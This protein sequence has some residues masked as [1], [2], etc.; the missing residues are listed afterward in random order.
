MGWRVRISG[1]GMALGY[2]H[3]IYKQNKFPATCPRLRL[4]ERV[5]L[6]AIIVGPSRVTNRDAMSVNVTY[7]RLHS[8]A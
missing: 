4:A 8:F 6:E 5:H 7:A 2:V 3:Q 1:E